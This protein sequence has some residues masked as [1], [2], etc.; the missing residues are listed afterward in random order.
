MLSEQKPQGKR[1]VFIER[2]DAVEIATMSLH[3]GIE[4]RPFQAEGPSIC[5]STRDDEVQTVSKWLKRKAEAA[6][7]LKRRSERYLGRGLVEIQRS[8]RRSLITEVCKCTSVDFCTEHCKSL[9]TI[10]QLKWWCSW[11]ELHVACTLL[12]IATLCMYMCVT[13]NSY[14]ACLLALK[15]DLYILTG[16]S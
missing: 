2:E 16:A 11:L 6:K 13:R 9:L 5:P 12:N 8:G 4:G 10:S 3:R 15:L 14:F 1:T 7:R